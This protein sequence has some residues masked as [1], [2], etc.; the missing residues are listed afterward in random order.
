MIYRII[1]FLIVL[2]A[3]VEQPPVFSFDDK[4]THRRLTEL[5]LKNAGFEKFLNEQFTSL[6]DYSSVLQIGNES[7]TIIQC[8]Q[9]GAFLGDDPVCR[10]VNHFHDPTKSWDKAMLTDFKW[11]AQS[12]C[13][14]NYPAFNDKFSNITWAT[15]F[16][17]KEQALLNPAVNND[18]YINNGRNWSTARDF[19]YKS[20]IAPA[21]IDRERYLAETFLTLGH[22]LHLLQDMAVPAHTRNDFSQGH[23]QNIG[24]PE[25][26]W[27]GGLVT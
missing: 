4:N 26:L 27:V 22:V 5:A 3:C 24:C 17:D 16:V 7:R 19:F 23:I 12:Y 9:E 20:L 10:A 11:Y 1:C 2:L 15:G 18:P 14:V 21:S 13:A 6:L 8:V 25:K